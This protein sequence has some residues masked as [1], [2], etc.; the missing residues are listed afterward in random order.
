MPA[1]M[2][3]S[4][5]RPPFGLPEVPVAVRISRR[6]CRRPEKRQIFRL[7]GES[8]GESPIKTAIG[9]Y[10]DLVCI[11]IRERAPNAVKRKPKQQRTKR[12]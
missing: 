8:S 7:I 6:S 9:R 5:S 3:R 12:N 4:A 1:K 10:D 2:A 11:D